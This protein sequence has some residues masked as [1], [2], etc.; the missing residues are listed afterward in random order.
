V[1]DGATLVIPGHGPATTLGEEAATNP[2]V[3]A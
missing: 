2:F 1:L 3:R